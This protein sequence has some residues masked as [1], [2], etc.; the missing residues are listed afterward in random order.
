[1]RTFARIGAV[2]AVGAAMLAGGLA[3]APAA[4]SDGLSFEAPKAASIQVAPNQRVSL[5]SSHCWNMAGWTSRLEVRKAGTSKWTTLK[6]VRP[7]KGAQGCDSYFQ[8]ST[9]YT[10]T[11]KAVGAYEVRE[12]YSW[13]KSRY[14]KGNISETRTIYVGMNPP[15]ISKEEF[16]AIADGMDLAQ[17]RQIVGSEGTLTNSYTIGDRT[18]ETWE[19]G[20]DYGKYGSASVEFVNGLTTSFRYMI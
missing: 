15:T 13:R 1:M 19:W 3:L 17:V 6:K 7:R 2:A 14:Y 11:P 4:A 5:Q 9:R 10:W 20:T 18:Y 8:W 12:R 16:A